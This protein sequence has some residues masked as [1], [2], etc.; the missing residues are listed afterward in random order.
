MTTE[1]MRTRDFW[2]S[3]APHLHIENG[4]LLKNIAPIEFSAT[5][6]RETAAQ[7]NEEGYFQST[8][9]WDIDIELMA[10]TIRS[11]TAEFLSPVF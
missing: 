1:H 8:V 5:S 9:N 4:L 2:R 10:H 3:F 6:C 11:L 7:L